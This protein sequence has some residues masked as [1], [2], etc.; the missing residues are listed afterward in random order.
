MAVAPLNL[1]PRLQAWHAAG[2][3]SLLLDLPLRDFLAAANQTVAPPVP[4][5]GA[6]RLKAATATPPMPV[7]PAAAVRPAAHAGPDEAAGSG[8][9][10]HNLPE[11]WK[12]VLQKVGPA[13]I[14][15]IYPELGQ[16]LL[17]QADAARGRALRGII[18]GLQLKK[19]S[20][21]FWPASLPASLPGGQSDSAEAVSDIF[22]FGLDHLGVKFLA[23]FG[24]QALAGTAYRDLPLRPFSEQ[25]S[26]GRLILALPGFTE[27]LSG[28]AKLESITVF[29]RAVFSR[30]F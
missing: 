10:V 12:R 17:L 20:S 4:A 28:Q 29:L 27:I 2:L 5:A 22:H 11:Q 13:P 24:P 26:D 7:E 3:G 19:G 18:A 1:T 9:S 15:W 23:A 8:L 25:I 14:A 21:T 16:D 30:Y 6:E